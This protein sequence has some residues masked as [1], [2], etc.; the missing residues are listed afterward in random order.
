MSKIPNWLAA[1]LSGF[2]D[3]KKNKFET[4]VQRMKEFGTT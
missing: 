4:M 2:D 3:S 1:K